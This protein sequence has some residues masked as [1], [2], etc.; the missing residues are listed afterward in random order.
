MILLLLLLML[1]VLMNDYARDADESRND[2]VNCEH[3]YDMLRD[4]AYDE[5]TTAANYD[6]LMVMVMTI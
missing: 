1:I 5:A 6:N 3:S 2:G 4:D